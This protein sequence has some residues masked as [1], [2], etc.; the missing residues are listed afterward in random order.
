MVKPFILDSRP[1]IQALE[2]R[3]RGNDV[4]EITL[5]QFVAFLCGPLRSGLGAA[6]LLA[7][8]KLQAKTGGP[9]ADAHRAMADRLR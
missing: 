9:S 5:P 4:V 1:P 6:A 2:G 8:S 7:T 3:L